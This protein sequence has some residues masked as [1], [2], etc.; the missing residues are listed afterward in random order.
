MRA[1]LVL[2]LVVA[3]GYGQTAEA[4]RLRGP[5]WIGK[6][7]ARIRTFFGRDSGVGLNDN[8]AARRYIQSTAQLRKNW[9]KLSPEQRAE[10]LA[11]CVNN[12]LKTIGVPGC[13]ARIKEIAPTS[14]SFNLANWRINVD[15]RLVGKPNISR[16]KMRHVVSAF[17]HEARHSEQVFRVARLLA[18]QG[19][20]PI[21]IAHT[22]DIPFGV[23]KAAVKKPMS[24]SSPEAI[25]TKK[26]YDSMFGK[27]AAK[28]AELLKMRDAWVTAA[29]SG[30]GT[31]TQ[32]LGAILLTNAYQGLPE[33]VD[34]RRAERKATRA[35]KRLERRQTLKRAGSYLRGLATG[36]LPW[37]TKRGQAG[38]PA[39]P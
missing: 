31:G 34:A 27:D 22:M 30:K 9:Q 2:F 26:W 3:L 35:Y 19:R 8:K 23:A 39:S 25:A 14:G 29:T 7:A 38:S 24:P 15:R 10:G 5:A 4:R 21:Y 28:R 20:D 11:A 32:A 1:A 6:A 18:G 13:E 12:Q 37:R 17:Y 33:E 16:G 36:I